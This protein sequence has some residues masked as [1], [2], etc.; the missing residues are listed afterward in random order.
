MLKNAYP[1]G[2]HINKYMMD[3]DYQRTNWPVL[4][5]YGVAAVSTTPIT[6]LITTPITTLNTTPCL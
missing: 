3:D 1:F 4:F 5:N 2:G 6:T